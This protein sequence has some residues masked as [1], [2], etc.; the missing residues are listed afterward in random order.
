MYRS[1]SPR[2]Y[3]QSLHCLVTLLDR[4]NWNNFVMVRVAVDHKIRPSLLERL[5]MQGIGET[6]FRHVH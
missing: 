6:G 5:L 4:L 3:V 2:A 1:P